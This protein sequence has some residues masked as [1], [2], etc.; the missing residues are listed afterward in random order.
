[1]TDLLFA[2][3]LSAWVGWSCYMLGRMD[4]RQQEREARSKR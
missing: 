3:S 4:G 2:L 1:M